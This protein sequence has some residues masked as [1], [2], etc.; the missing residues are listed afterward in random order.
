M[1]TRLLGAACAVTAITAPAFAEPGW[2]GEGALAAGFTTGNTET[3]D[4]G[5][6]VEIHFEGPRYSHHG[7]VAF[8]YAEQDGL[9][10]KNR[11]FAAYQLDR[12][13]TERWFAF[14]R[15]S[16]EQ[17]EFSGFDSRA[18]LG[19]GAGYHVIDNDAT[20]WT[21]RAAPGLKIDDVAA[22]AA[23]VPPIAGGTE[24]SFAVEFGSEYAYAFNDAVTLSNDTSI[25]YAEVSTQMANRV[26]LTAQLM[27]A[28]SARFSVE[29]R[30]ESDP[31]PGREQTDTATRF[32]LVYG[33]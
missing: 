16:Y 33:F 29:V 24:Q 14:G 9:K 32:G 5:I 18:F 31:Q 8:D 22:D 30:H 12:V 19:A 27:D 1:R 26:A 17:D 7:E 25:I 23:A 13:L 11:A 3:T 21:L 4:V 10:S 28:L 20:S 6:G 15:V 2:S